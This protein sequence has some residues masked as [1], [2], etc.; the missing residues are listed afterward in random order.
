MGIKKYGNLFSFKQTVKK[1]IHV[2]CFLDLRHMSTFLFKISGQP[3]SSSEAL[4]DAVLDDQVQEDWGS[5][6]VVEDMDLEIL[7]DAIRNIT[8]T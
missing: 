4:I 1:S 8:P 6:P 5:A 3:F 7:S 2:A